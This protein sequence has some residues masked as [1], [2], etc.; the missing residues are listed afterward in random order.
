[1]SNKNQTVLSAVL[2]NQID[3]T[4]TVIDCV[5]LVS[6]NKLELVLTIKTN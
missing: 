6:V 3:V 1:M 5:K 4:Y 2:A